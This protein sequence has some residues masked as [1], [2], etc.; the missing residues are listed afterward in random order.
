M[1]YIKKTVRA[2]PVIEVRKTFSTRF[3]SKGGRRSSP[4]NAT[5]EKVK[6][7]NDR[8]AEDKLRWLLLANFKKGDWHLVAT[9]R[10]DARPTP[11][12]SKALLSK[13]F[14]DLRKHFKRIGQELK[15][16]EATEYKNRAIHHHIIIPSCDIRPIQQ[17][18]PYGKIRPTDITDTQ[19]LISLA[20]YLVKETSETFREKGGYK[21]RWNQSR[22]LVIPEPKTEIIR[23]GRWSDHPK[24][25]KGYYIDKTVG[26]SGDGVELYENP[27]TGNLCQFYRM[28]LNE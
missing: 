19:H 21:K 13:F 25:K 28:I 8:Y 3:G 2:G 23:V 4:K 6:R 10:R 20:S 5:P 15:Y 17:F 7:M 16:I 27:I 24:P 14:R 18:W 11:E 12:D 1:P 26:E 22:N 9:Y